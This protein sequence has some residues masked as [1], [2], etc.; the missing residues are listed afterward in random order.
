MFSIFMFS[1]TSNSPTDAP[2]NSESTRTNR[3]KLLL[4]VTNTA[5]HLTALLNRTLG[6]AAARIR[7]LF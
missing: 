7:K 3:F 5:N 4:P 1:S 6:S 2:Q